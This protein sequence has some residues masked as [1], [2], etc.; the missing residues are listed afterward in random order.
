M[1]SFLQYGLQTLEGNSYASAAAVRI[2]SVAKTVDDAVSQ[3]FEQAQKVRA[4]ISN[5]QL[6]AELARVR[7]VVGAEWFRRVD[8]AVAAKDRIFAAAATTYTELHE[9]TLES[10]VTALKTRLA[11]EWH[12]RLQAP[13]AAFYATAQ[14]KWADKDGKIDKAEV[15]ADV[16][17]TLGS[18]WDVQVTSVQQHGLTLYNA[19]VDYTHAARDKLVALQDSR[20]V[21]ERVTELVG[22]VRTKLG[23]AYDAVPRALLQ[24]WLEG[25]AKAAKED[26]KQ[27][28]AALDYNGDGEVSAS[29][30]MAAG[31]DLVSYVY[32]N[33]LNVAERQVDYWLP[34]A[35]EGDQAGV[36]QPHLPVEGVQQLC[37]VT[38]QR[39]KARVQPLV[40]GAVETARTRI[41]SSSTVSLAQKQYADV[42][43]FA[44]AVMSQ[45]Q[46]RAQTLVASVNEVAKP[47]T[48]KLQAAL[49]RGNLALQAL[50]ARVVAAADAGRAPASEAV[51]IA[52]QLVH[53]V[54]DG[55]VVELPAAAV[56]FVARSLG[57]RERDEAWQSTIEQLQALLLSLR[58][59][60]TV[61]ASAAMEQPIVTGNSDDEV[62]Y[63]AEPAPIQATQ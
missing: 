8:T 46:E 29:D 10:F 3:S 11:S 19:C 7:T 9:Q 37:S 34:E 55:P 27:L 35:T 59:I 17:R 39:V 56:A 32:R 40:A 25:A 33:A 50:R 2:N 4:E 44:T 52:Q 53:N 1:F 5:V 13:A 51:V 57:V 41:G 62:F 18:A 31:Q 23:Q 6:S 20:P 30:A 48:A 45:G 49:E 28:T 36:A 60:V 61:S 63:E 12:D 54:T 22:F 42:L 14:E 38:A 21:A 24:E 26:V 15:L 47:H 58:D 16:R 43:S